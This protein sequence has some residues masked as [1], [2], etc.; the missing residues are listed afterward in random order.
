M[1]KLLLPLV[2]G[3]A[4]AACG[5]DGA[6]PE[7]IATDVPATAAQSPET[8]VAYATA[9]VADVGD[10][11]SSALGLAAVDAPPTSETADPVDF[12]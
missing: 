12:D 5:G 7:A 11:T 9:L 2:A 3:L 4:L 8:W 10:E 6:E 1:N